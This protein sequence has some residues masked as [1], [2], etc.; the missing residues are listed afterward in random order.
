MRF[1]FSGHESFP[2]RYTWLPK[3][4]RAISEEPLLFDD[5]NQAMVKLGVG[6]NMVKSIRFWVQ[7]FGIANSVNGLRGYYITPFGHSIFHNDGLD[8]FLED[9]RTLWLLHWKIASLT[10][11]PLF[12]WHFLLNQWTE[13]DLS[14]TEIL[15]AFTQES[16]RMERPLS[17][18]TK[19]QH[20]DIFL[21]TYV[22]VR[23][24]KGG[25]ILEENL[26]CPLTELRL[27][28]PTG[29][30]VVGEERHRETIYAFRRDVKTEI[31]GPLLAY[32]LFDFWRAHRLNEATLSFGDV[33]TAMG[34]VG[35]LFRLS[36]PDLRT[37]LEF[38][39]KD[40]QQMFEYRSSAAAPRVVKH[41]SLDEQME[42]TL[43]T[44]IYG[45]PANAYFAVQ[46]P[47][48]AVEE[49]A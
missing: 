3:A 22:P 23:A 34:S 36:E 42:A 19:E 32:C 4:Y 45:R 33:A 5:D 31:S 20:F 29:E 38:L 48:E 14:R 7:A 35:R 41:G 18:F 39:S 15:R 24:R 10:E 37:R 25:E 2:C 40:S 27:L 11:D 49:N 17:D 21:H 16:E 44:G 9:V 8:P 28:M 43:L 47:I 46:P 26:D 1:R 13:P 6:K 12:A 30:R